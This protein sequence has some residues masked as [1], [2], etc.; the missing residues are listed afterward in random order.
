V[1]RK[2]E[3]AAFLP[4]ERLIELKLP[5]GLSAPY[6]LR[7][8]A[9][10]LELVRAAMLPLTLEEQLDLSVR[11]KYREPCRLRSIAI[12]NRAAVIVPFTFPTAEHFARLMTEL[13]G[14]G[15]TPPCV[16]L[17]IGPRHW[18]WAPRGSRTTTTYCLPRS[19]RSRSLIGTRQESEFLGRR[20]QRAL[21]PCRL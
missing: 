8:L 13:A 16:D 17:M 4:I 3:R 1:A 12:P 6:R 15:K 20:L 2:G 18:N 19:Q 14:K 10:V 5:S 11:E 7:D 21:S 9:D